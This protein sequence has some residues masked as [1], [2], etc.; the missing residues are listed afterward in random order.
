MLTCLAMLVLQQ[1]VAS[2][3][4]LLEQVVYLS[5]SALAGV[6]RF[7]VLR[8]VVFAHSRAQAAVTVPAA[9]PVHTSVARSAAPTAS[10]QLCRAA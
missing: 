9:R 1:V 6:A 4:A 2:P 3:G 7:V 8:L 5:A 10:A